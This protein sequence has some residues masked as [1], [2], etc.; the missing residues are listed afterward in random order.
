[1]AIPVQKVIKA[2]PAMLEFR[3]QKDQKVIPVIPVLKV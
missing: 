1:M 2:T 3:V